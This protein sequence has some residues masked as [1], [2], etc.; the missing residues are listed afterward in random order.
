MKYLIFLFSILVLVLSGGVAAAQETIELPYPTYQGILIEEI[1]YIENADNTFDVSFVFRNGTPVSIGIRDAKSVYKD[2][3]YKFVRDLDQYF[4]LSPGNTSQFLKSFTSTS[5]YRQAIKDFAAGYNTIVT[6]GI[7]EGGARVSSP[8]DSLTRIENIQMSCDNNTILVEAN[9]VETR[10][11]NFLDQVLKSYSIGSS[12]FNIFSKSEAG[13]HA[14]SRLGITLPD[15]TE[16]ISSELFLEKLSANILKNTEFKRVVFPMVAT[17]ETES[18]FEYFTSTEF[19]EKVLWKEVVKTGLSLTKVDSVSEEQFG[20]LMALQFAKNSGPDFT[21]DLSSENLSEILNNLY[22]GAYESVL[23]SSSFARLVKKAIS[24]TA[25]IIDVLEITNFY[26]NGYPSFFIPLS[27]IECGENPNEAKVTSVSPRVLS[28]GSGGDISLTGYDLDEITSISLPGCEEVSSPEIL[29]RE[30]Y[31]VFC[32]PRINVFET[33]VEIMTNGKS[34]PVGS[35]V[36]GDSNP[37]IEELT[38]STLKANKPTFL[39]LTGNSLLNAT[40]TVTGCAD[41][42][43]VSRFSNAIEYKCDGFQPGLQSVVISK[44]TGEVIQRRTYRFDAATKPSVRTLIGPPLKEGQEALLEVLG[45]DFIIDESIAVST[46]VYG[47]ENIEEGSSVPVT[48]SAFFSFRCTPR[49]NIPSVDVEV[50]AQ[51]FVGGELLKSFSRGVQ[52]A[53]VQPLKLSTR[54]LPPARMCEQYD[55]EIKFSGGVRPYS[56]PVFKDSTIGFANVV[57]CNEDEEECVAKFG[58][59]RPTETFD[60]VDTLRLSGQICTGIDE[61]YIFTGFEDAE[62]K[63]AVSEYEFEIIPSSDVCYCELKKNGGDYFVD[64]GLFG[65]KPSK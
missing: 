50:F 7:V 17:G 14:A 21:V 10:T 41:L 39:K 4:L 34:F 28:S 54:T 47:C 49:G 6:Q 16:A 30:V 52:T 38:V 57:E 65:I 48:N 29:G 33:D 63:T 2:G 15:S 64:T 31:R 40:I 60:G 12:A 32:R 3:S 22:F 45:S 42:Q 25:Q 58:L 26:N 20:A 56:K 23:E 61:G 43:R 37:S 27:F 51:E 8:G 9:S 46:S 5:G 36:F 19:F 62:G 59:F 13:K 44:S 53:T 18:L 55:Q 35:I 1:S 11:A 24:G